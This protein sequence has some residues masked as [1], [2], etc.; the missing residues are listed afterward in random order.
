MMRIRLSFDPHLASRQA[1]DR[2]QCVWINCE[3]QIITEFPRFT[4]QEVRQASKPP[5]PSACSCAL[6]RRYSALRTSPYAT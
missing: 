1:G 4:L 3:R 2:T 5:P 6:S